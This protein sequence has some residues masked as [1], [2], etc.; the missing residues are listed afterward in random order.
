[1]IAQPQIGPMRKSLNVG[2]CS[3]DTC[4]STCF[5]QWSTNSTMHLPYL[6]GDNQF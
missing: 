4:A 6:I 2:G 1:M 3:S 5:I